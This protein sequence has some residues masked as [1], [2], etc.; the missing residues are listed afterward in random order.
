MALLP[1]FCPL[2]SALTLALDSGIPF[3]VREFIVDERM[4]ALFTITL[5]AFSPDLAIDFDAVVGQTARFTISRG[6][7]ERTWTGICLA[8][9]LVASEENGL[10]TYQLIIVPVLWLLTQRTNRRIF[11]HL[12]EPEMVKRLL[13]EHRLD[14]AWRLSETYKLRQ[15]R[16]QYDE[17][18]HAFVQRML[19]DTGISSFFENQ[20]GKTIFIASDAPQCAEPR[21]MPIPYKAEITM[22]TGEYVTNVKIARELKPGRVM[23]RDRDYRLPPDY[24][25][26]ASVQA[27]ALDRE[28]R[29]EQFEVIP[30]RFLVQSAQGGGTPVADDRGMYRSDERHAD[31][32]AQKRIEA[33]RE[34]ATAI[35]F[36]TNALDLAPGVVV[37]VHGH[38]YQDLAEGMLIVA[39]RLSG[40]F[41]ND[42]THHIEARPITQPY[43][44][45]SKTPKPRVQGIE[46]ATVVGPAGEEIHCD[47]LG[48]VRVSFHWDRESSM[49][50][51]SSCW[52]PVSQAHAGAGHGVFHLPR[53]GQEVLVD[54]LNG[55]PDR[56]V[57]VG[58]VH[59]ALQRVPYRLP[60]NK[61]QSV[62]RSESS[63]GGGGYNEILFE[64][65]KG[66]ELIRMHAERDMATTVERDNF[67]TIERDAIAT[68]RRDQKI[69]VQRD[70]EMLVAR[71]ATQLVQD[72]V[73]QSC[74]FV[75]YAVC[76]RQRCRRR[77]RR[78]KTLGRRIQRNARHGAVCIT[79]G[80]DARRD[81][82][83]QNETFCGCGIDYA[84]S[85]G[86]DYSRRDEYRLGIEW[87]N[88]RDGNGHRRQRLGDRNGRFGR[89]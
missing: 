85:I 3:D 10:S 59:T 38:A 75:E 55:D 53:I 63:P 4:S 68:V 54:F 86:R 32:V 21:A 70:A 72:N 43:R 87:T 47:E 74:R 8:I 13:S 24:A 89:R 29:M 60:E 69:R 76:R 12:S 16:T 26:K 31:Q 82:G 71:N 57:I 88:Y 19:E 14:Q 52:I 30:G 7:D 79:R 42:W 66:A 51:Q 22:V 62:W 44:P 49:D 41:D 35:S 25:L 73:R 80:R 1:G 2:G 46:S 15:Y 9:E 61:T 20:D 50:E 34:G 39:G 27:K 17:S 11:Q 18:D 45:S 84:G 33:L 5:R 64:D 77:G 37:H 78:S 67:T 6:S 36:E 58:R 40:K 56:P 65:R 48:R 28:T 23:I 81:L 83:W